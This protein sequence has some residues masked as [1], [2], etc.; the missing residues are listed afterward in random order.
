MRLGGS[1]EQGPDVG[2][3]G[4]SGKHFPVGSR[5]TNLGEIKMGYELLRWG[6]SEG[7]IWG[8][9]TRLRLSFQVICAI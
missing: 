2:I 5:I 8:L 7:L 3:V 4:S 9:T 6:G 1:W